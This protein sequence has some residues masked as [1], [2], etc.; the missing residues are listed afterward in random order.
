MALS[1]FYV[2]QLSH[3]MLFNFLENDKI[4]DWSKFSGFADDTLMFTQTVRFVFYCMEKNLWEKE[5][6]RYPTFS[7]FPND[8]FIKVL[9]QGR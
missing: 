4:L 6:F 5:K 8:V 7:H 2:S 3:P 9:P 1:S